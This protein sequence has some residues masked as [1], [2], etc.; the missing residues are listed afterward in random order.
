MALKYTKK[1]L[2]HFMHPKN[3]GEMPNADAQAT[4]GSPACG[5]M[6]TMAIK[7]DPKT[8]KI[9]DV[10]FKS[11][12]CASNIATASVITEM[13][14]GKTLEEAKKLGW[15]SAADELGGLPAVKMHCSLLAAKT[16]AEAIR[17]YEEEH[18]LAKPREVG[19][20][21]QESVLRELE[22]VLNPEIGLSIV[23]LK[24]VK[25]I[26]IEDGVVNI[27]ISLGNTDPEFSKVIGEEIEEHVKDLK[28][29]KQVKVSFA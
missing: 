1:V 16:L 27:D 18:G 17:K 15:R 28:G 5:D 23:R 25:K 6:V 22:G 12:G 7:V 4:D 3:M 24:M 13:A 9:T 26:G 14:K 29:V 20:L 2:E 11:Y 10:K 19:G 8:L 21:T